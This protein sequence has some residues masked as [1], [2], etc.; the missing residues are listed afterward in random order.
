MAL[1]WTL[2]ALVLAIGSA[3]TGVAAVYTEH[4]FGP[5]RSYD[6]QQ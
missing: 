4:L 1:A 3:L 5:V 2:V 6:E